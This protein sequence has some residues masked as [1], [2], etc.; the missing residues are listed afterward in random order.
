[1][2]EKTW[3]ADRHLDAPKHEMKFDACCEPG[4]CNEP[5]EQTQEYG[6]CDDGTCCTKKKESDE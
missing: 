3:Y 6:W 2:T 5:V 1:M 4:C